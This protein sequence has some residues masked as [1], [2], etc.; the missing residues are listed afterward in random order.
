MMSETSGGWGLVFAG[1]YERDAGV[2]RGDGSFMGVQC[3]VKEKGVEEK[4]RHE[5]VSEV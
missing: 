2:K 5:D 3:T 4:R 1:D